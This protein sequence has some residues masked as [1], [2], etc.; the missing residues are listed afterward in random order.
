MGIHVA[1]DLGTHSVYRFTDP[2]A[3]LHCDNPGCFVPWVTGAGVIVWELADDRPSGSR[4]SERF[5]VGCSPACLHAAMDAHVRSRRR[6]SEPMQ[7][8][9]WL[10]A[11]RSSIDVD[12]ITTPI[13]T[14][15]GVT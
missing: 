1:E 15:A 14:F 10:D 9:D 4:F 7:V 5:L 12:P 2:D 11:L 8:G 13:G 6:W 3:F